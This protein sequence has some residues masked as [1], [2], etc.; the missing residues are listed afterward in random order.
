MLEPML[1]VTPRFK[2]IWEEFLEEWKNE[3]PELPIYLVLSNLARHI[4][5]LHNEGTE[6]ELREI[7]AVVERW[8]LDGD[9]YVKEAATVGLL[10]DLQNTNLVGIGKP[11]QF[12]RFLGPESKRWWKKVED[13]WEKGEI[14]RDE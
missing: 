9:G 13:F 8:H 10:E 3:E 11:A 12:V 1:E 6:A 5:T 7:F 4:A 2:P 14:I